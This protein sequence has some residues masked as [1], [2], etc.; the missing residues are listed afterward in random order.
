METEVLGPA[1]SGNGAARRS[2]LNAVADHAGQVSA[3]VSGLGLLVIARHL[4]GSLRPLRAERADV[5][6]RRNRHLPARGGVFL[7][8]A[9]AQR[10]GA[11]IQVELHRRHAFQSSAA[12]N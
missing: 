10:A 1:A 3:V 4:L 9:A 8:L 12:A 5:L 7:G 2:T 6:G 11:H